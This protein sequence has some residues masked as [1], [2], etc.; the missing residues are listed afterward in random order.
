[1]TTNEPST[2][3]WTRTYLSVIV[4]EILALLGLLWLQSQFRI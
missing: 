2:R 4:V 1:M 3:N